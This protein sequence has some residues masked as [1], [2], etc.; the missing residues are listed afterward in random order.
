MESGIYAI[1]NNINGKLYIGQSNNISYRWYCEK[2][3]AVNRILKDDFAKYGL[4]NF[5]FYIIELCPVELLSEREIFYISLYHTTNKDFGYNISAGGAFNKNRIYSDWER[6]ELR[7][8]TIK[9][10]NERHKKELQNYRDTHRNEIRAF[11]RDYN[12]KR[13]ENKTYKIWE[14]RAKKNRS[15]KRKKLCKDPIIGD[16]LSFGALQGR[17]CR[18]KEKYRNYKINDLII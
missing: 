9:R 13:K 18:Y 7:K 3:G 4:E 1:Q 8:Q 5:N 17:M 14:E 16:I 12:K 11:F 15:E 6:R 10:F 2:H